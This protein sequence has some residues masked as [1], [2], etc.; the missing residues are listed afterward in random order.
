METNRSPQHAKI[1]GLSDQSKSGNAETAPTLRRSE[2]IEKGP[3]ISTAFP[4]VGIDE[5]P[6]AD[7]L[8]VPIGAFYDKIPEQLLTSKKHDP[9]RLIYI[10]SEDVVS[11][12]ETKEA[13]I[14][15]S[16]LSLSCPEIFAHPI[17]SADDIA[18]TFSVGRPKTQPI[19][20]GPDADAALQENAQPAGASATSESEIGK[21]ASVEAGSAKSDTA[22]GSDK[23]RVKLAPILANLP[24]EIELFPAPILKDPETEIDLPLDLV[25][26]QLKNGRVALA[27]TAFCAALPEDLRHLF[28]TLE[29]TAEIPIPL[30]EVFRELSSDTIKLREDYEVG[31]SLE[32]I[33]TPFTVH[34]EEDAIRYGPGPGY[35]AKAPGDSGGKSAP[36]TDAMMRGVASVGQQTNPMESGTPKIAAPPIPEVNFPATFDSPA[37]QAL[38]MTDEVLDLPKTMQKISELPGLRACLLTTTKGTKLWGESVDPIGAPA[39]SSAFPGL[40]QQVAS[41]LG[42]TRSLQGMTLYFDRDPLSIILSNELCLVVMHDSRPFRPGVMEKILAVMQELDKISHTK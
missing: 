28:G 8:S 19:E 11:D 3:M 18:I 5:S 25:K 4:P 30:R 32:P 17:E 16:I 42:E 39:L 23:I 40:L 6:G 22:A 13:T 36:E 21:A 12:E 7:L 15:L 37:L 1:M 26:A 27:G 29:P 31:Y 14:L 38:F 10:A 9:A 2:T 24:P 20:D 33:R 41:T 35:S 34:A